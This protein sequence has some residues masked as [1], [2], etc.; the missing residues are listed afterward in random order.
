MYGRAA[1]IWA[2]GSAGGAGEVGGDDVGGVPVER[3][4]VAVVAHR[5]ARVGVRGGLL[6]IAERHPGVER[7]SD[8]SMPKRVRAD[9]LADAGLAGKAPHD[10]GRAAAVQPLAGGSEEDRPLRPLAD[11]EVDRPGGARRERDSDDLAALL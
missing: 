10:P 11:G 7:G 2:G 6:D 1:P 9:P 4:P 8:E 3:H 5:G